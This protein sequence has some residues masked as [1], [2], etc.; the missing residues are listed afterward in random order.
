MRPQGYLLDARARASAYPY[1]RATPAHG[2]YTGCKVDPDLQ[3]VSNT[4]VLKVN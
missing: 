4:L 1:S 2:M 3:L